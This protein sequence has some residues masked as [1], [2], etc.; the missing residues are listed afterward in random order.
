MRSTHSGY[1]RKAKRVVRFGL[2]DKQGREI[3]ARIVT[4]EVTFRPA[5]EDARSWQTVAPGHYYGLNVWATRNG[6]P[7]GAIQSDRYFS[8]IA[9]RH[10]ALVKYI[11]DAKK[12]A[13]K[14]R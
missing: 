13:A 4:F 14:K 6:V 5:P 7:F 1:T 12:R 9:A 3:G 8:T 2:L 10:K 11:A